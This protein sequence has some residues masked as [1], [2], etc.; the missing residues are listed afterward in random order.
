MLLAVDTETTGTDFFHGCKPFMITACDGKSSYVFEGS[1]NPVTREVTWEEDELDEF[2]SLVKKAT[3]VIFHNTN[4]DIRALE[5]IGISPDMFWPKIEDTLLASHCICSGDTHNL[6]DLAVKYLNY[7]DKDEDDLAEIVK[8]RV[9]EARLKGYRVAKAG[10][11]HF[12]GIRANG[13]QFWKMDYWL[14][15]DACRVY[16]VRDVERTLLL[17]DAFKPSL[18]ADNLWDVYQLRKKLLPIAYRMQTVGKNFYKDEAQKMI[19]QL[20]KEMEEHRWEIKRQ[21]GIPY[22][23]DPNK[24]QHLVHLVHQCLKIPVKYYTDSSNKTP[25][26]DKKAIDSYAKEF[27]AP[28]LKLLALYKKK[29]KQATDIEGYLNWLDENNRTHSNL[30]ITGT[31]ETRQSSNSPNDQNSDKV[32]RFLFG[33]TPGNVWISTDLVNIELRIWAYTVGNRELIEAFEQGKS[34]HQ[35]IMEIIFPEQMEAYRQAKRLQD[36]QHTETHKKALR[37][38]GFVKNGNFARIY[39]ATDVKTNETYHN[40]KNAPNYCAKID[41][42]FP[43]IKEFTKSRVAMAEKNYLCY[44]VFAI[45]TMGGYRLDVPPNEPFK[46]TNYYVQGTA[47]LVMSQAMI[48]WTS[49]PFYKKFGCELISQVHDSMDTEVKIVPALPLIIEAKCEAI[50][51]AGRKY[52]PTCEA[53]WKLIYHPSDETNPIIQELIHKS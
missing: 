12:P 53:D 49:H 35:M 16:A 10:D 3:K 52:I 34:V 29:Q 33:P 4:F 37:T 9:R 25:A 42:R 46:A 44:S 51:S 27:N 7:S 2:R 47:G 43:G 14:A 11:W 1:V 6:K 28:T 21:A 40:G 39:G 48:E 17:W 18:L 45:H 23:F 8:E 36:N 30:N 38:Y 19:T 22:K 41:A 31:R 24:R 20:R 13:T 26:M 32:L 50:A 5:S 15:M